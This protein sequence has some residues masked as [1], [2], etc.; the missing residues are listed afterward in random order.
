MTERDAPAENDPQTGKGD[1]WG[2]EF[3]DTADADNEPGSQE[4]PK[5]PSPA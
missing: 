1:V 4:P 3:V 5:D 2:D